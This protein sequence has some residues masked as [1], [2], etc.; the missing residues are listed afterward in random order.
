[1]AV[2]YKREGLE[3][4]RRSLSIPIFEGGPQRIWGLT[5]YLLDQLLREVIL[6]SFNEHGAELMLPLVEEAPAIGDR[7]HW[8]VGR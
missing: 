3:L 5:A 8:A 4:E 1:M 7:E 2:P 6:P